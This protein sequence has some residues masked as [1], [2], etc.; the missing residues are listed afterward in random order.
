MAQPRRVGAITWLKAGSQIE[1][2]ADQ[3]RRRGY[4]GSSTPAMLLR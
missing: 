3:A 4:F 2:Q 1:Q